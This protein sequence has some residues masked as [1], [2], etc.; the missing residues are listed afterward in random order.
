MIYL[1]SYFQ[2]IALGRYWRIFLWSYVQILCRNKNVGHD[3]VLRVE[4]LFWYILHGAF[5][6]VRN[7]WSH[8]QDNQKKFNSC[9]F[10]FL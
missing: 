2:R 3:D 5:A 10:Y 6:I 1:Y 7:F 8:L 9:L 4:K